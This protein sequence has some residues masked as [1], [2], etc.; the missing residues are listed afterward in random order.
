MRTKLIGLI[1][2]LVGCS[3]AIFCSCKKGCGISY[4]P[5]VLTDEQFSGAGYAQDFVPQEGELVFSVSSPSAA[6][7]LLTIR[8]LGKAEAEIVVN[9]EH[10]TVVFDDGNK[11]QEKTTSVHLMA[12]ENS[13]SILQTNTAESPLMIDYIEF[14]KK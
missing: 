11:W 1:V 10:G 6:N 13:I 12:G 7:V 9:G 4:V 8:G 5:E 3:A 14:E 2:G